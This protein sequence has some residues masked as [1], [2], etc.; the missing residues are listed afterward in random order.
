MIRKYDEMQDDLRL[1]FNPM[2][3]RLVESFSY[4]FDVKITFYSPRLDEWMVGYHTDASDYCSMVQKKLKIRYRCLYQDRQAC[5]RCSALRRQFFYHCHGGLTEAVLPIELDGNIVAYAMIGQFRMTNEAPKAML[6]AWRATDSDPEELG[7]AFLDRPYF[8]DERL[9]KM[10][11]IFSATLQFLISTQN[12]KL[13]KAELV[14]QVMAFV[15]AHIDEPVSIGEVASAVGK[16]P[17]TVTHTLKD[18]M[19][20]SFKEMVI[21]QKLMRFERIL[22]ADPA[23]SIGQAAHMV[24]YDDALYFSRLYH[25]KRGGT[26]SDY[27]ETVRRTKNISPS[28]AEKMMHS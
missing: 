21:T 20:V 3:K 28:E 27:L 4:C 9:S 5:K 19:G 6:E 25:T 2:V 22:L 7:K 26:P 15:E 13:R 1:Y 24:G 12:M 16:S 23:L 8:S 10:L 14:E 17:S 18:K 11:Y